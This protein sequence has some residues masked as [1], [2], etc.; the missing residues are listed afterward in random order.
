MEFRQLLTSQGWTKVGVLGSH[1]VQHV[2]LERIRTAAVTGL[3]TFL[4]YQSGD[5]L[6]AV[7]IM[8]ALDLTDTE[9]Q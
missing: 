3:T 8:Q 9:V 2:L 1:Q 4:G 5:T 6:V 7:A